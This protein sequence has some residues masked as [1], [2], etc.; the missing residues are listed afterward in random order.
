VV[1]ETLL[2]KN[3]HTKAQSEKRIRAKRND[4]HAHAWRHSV[5]MMTHIF[6]HPDYTVGPGISPGLLS[7]QP[8]ALAGSAIGLAIAPVGKFTPPRRRIKLSPVLKRAR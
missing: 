7:L 2:A 1:I 3:W 6:F 5:R 8:Q 4:A